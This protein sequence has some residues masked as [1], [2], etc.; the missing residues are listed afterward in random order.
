LDIVLV[1][2]GSVPF[3]LAA[4]AIKPNLDWHPLDDIISIRATFSGKASN[5]AP[6][7]MM[8]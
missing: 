3:R 2:H 7:S 6:S 5:P 1:S 8:K 4:S